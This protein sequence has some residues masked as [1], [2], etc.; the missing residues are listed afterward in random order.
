MDFKLNHPNK[1]KSVFVA[2]IMPKRT[3]PDAFTDIL[4]I[5]SSKGSYIKN[6]R[7]RGR[8]SVSST[9]NLLVKCT[10]D[11]CTEEEINLHIRL[12]TRCSSYFCSHCCNLD[13]EIMKILNERTTTIGF[14]PFVQNPH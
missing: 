14:V 7:K 5:M 8:T 11:N 13:Q 3:L 12:C 4:N 2:V 9:T 6:L 1:I 10:N